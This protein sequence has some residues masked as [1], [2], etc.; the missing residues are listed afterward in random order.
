MERRKIKKTNVGQRVKVAMVQ[1][2]LNISEV[3]RRINC[4]RTN[5]YDIL[6]RSSMNTALLMQLCVVTRV[7]IFEYLSQ[8]A[9][10]R[11]KE[12]KEGGQYCQIY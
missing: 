10:E 11:I 6:D 8:E 4:A 9:E 1:R 12:A 7:N 2:G 5:M 3:A